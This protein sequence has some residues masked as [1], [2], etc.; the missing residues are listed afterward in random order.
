MN[1]YVIALPVAYKICSEM[2]GKKPCAEFVDS[3]LDFSEQECAEAA[4]ASKDYYAFC[5]VYGEREFEDAFAYGEV[6]L[7]PSN[8]FIRIFE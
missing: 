5:G 2:T 3:V 7:N 4:E 6:Q 1:I 8:V